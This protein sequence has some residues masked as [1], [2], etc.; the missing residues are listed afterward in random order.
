MAVVG[1]VSPTRSTSVMD[2]EKRWKNLQNNAVYAELWSV[3]NISI[4]EE[5]VEDIEINPYPCW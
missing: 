2:A 3:A 1:T 5:E 4:D